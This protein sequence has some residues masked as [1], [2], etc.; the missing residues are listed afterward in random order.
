MAHRVAP[1]AEADLDDIW[2]YVAQES[3]S[4]EVANRLIDTLTGR[5][6]SSPAIP[7]WAEG[8][9]TSLELACGVF[10]LPSTSLFITLRMKI[11]L[12]FAWHTAAARLRGY[13]A[14]S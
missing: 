6:F 1:R 4:V 12:S 9:M 2:Y 10:P 3:G 5:F 11:F 13:S 14:S 8:V 7:A